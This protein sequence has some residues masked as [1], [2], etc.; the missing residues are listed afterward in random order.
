MDIEKENEEIIRVNSTATRITAIDCLVKAV[1]NSLTAI[2]GD[3][4][5]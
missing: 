5:D 2:L 3:N 1:E 4:V